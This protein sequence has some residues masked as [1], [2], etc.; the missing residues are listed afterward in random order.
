MIAPVYPPVLLAEGLATLDIVS[1]G[2]LIVGLGAGYMREYA[3]FGV[4]FEDASRGS[5]SA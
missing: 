4:P 1:E 5:R 3:A 2:R